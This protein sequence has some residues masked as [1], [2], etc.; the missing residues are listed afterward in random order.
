MLKEIPIKEFEKRKELM[1]K[2]MAINSIDII[3][4]VGHE[5]ASQ[6]IRYFSNYQPAFEGAG[7]LIPKKG[8][9]ILL[10]GPESKKLGE[11]WGKLN[12]VE[13]ML[14]FR[15]SSDPDYP[16]IKL[17][18]FDDIFKEIGRDFKIKKIGIVGSNILYFDISEAI[19][20]AAKKYGAEIIKA[21]KIM[22][23]IRRNKSG[24]EIEILKNAFRISE[25]S[26]K[27]VLNKI[28]VGMTELEILGLVEYEIKKNGG[29]GSAYPLW[30]TSGKNTNSAIG[31]SSYKK[32]K[33]NEIIQ[34]SV[35]AR[36]G[37]YASSVSRP[38]CFGKPNREII[39]L[40]NM[41]LKAEKYVNSILKSGERAKEVALNYKDFLYK[42]GYKEYYLYG[43]CH[44]IG[45]SE[46]EPPWIEE[47]S[48]FILENNMTFCLDIFLGSENMGLRW[49]DGVLITNEG[50]K[51][52]SSIEEGIIIL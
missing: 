29:E 19:K 43:P 28:D 34:I 23:E 30:V 40:L 37:G 46:C 52:L 3:L 41:G 42:N 51:N 12:R 50:V 26:M 45:L 14:E 10:V 32:I 31:K 13:T 21:D 33:K 15:D 35:G 48:E 16:G 36:L 2:N 4:C 8:E 22:K 27:N 24:I 11:K 49:E 44:S 25:L 9:A 20:I 18:T 7:V 38:I 39:D 5:A 6:H 47:D 1:Q 17:T